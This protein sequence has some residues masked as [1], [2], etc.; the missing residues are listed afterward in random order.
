MLCALAA[1]GGRT[2]PPPTGTV[3]PPHVLNSTATASTP[4]ATQAG[5]PTAMATVAQPRQFPAPPL[6]V[7]RTAYTMRIHLQCQ[8]TITITMDAAKTPYT[9]NSFAFL[10]AHHWFDHTSCHR[11]VTQ[12]IHVLQCG[13]PTASGTGGPGYTIPDENLKGATYPTGTVAMANTGAPH[14]GGSQFFLVYGD[15]SSLPASYTP[16]GR[17]TSGLPI[18]RKIAAEGEDDAF[19]QGDGHPND[20]VV[21]TSLTVTKAGSGR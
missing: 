12:G 21:I 18:L 4:A 6:T 9:V 13:D 17:I 7:A 14:S 19:G 11:L 16:F 2:A 1:C 10:A 5:C 8:G 20:P 3:T 15:S